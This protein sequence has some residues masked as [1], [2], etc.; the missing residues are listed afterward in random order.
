M[1]APNSHPLP[2]IARRRDPVV[3]RAQLVVG[4]LEAQTSEFR[5]A[6]V[7]CGLASCVPVRRPGP[8]ALTHGRCGVCALTMGTRTSGAGAA[9]RFGSRRWH[10]IRARAGERFAIPDL[11][12]VACLARS[13]LVG[14]PT[15][16]LAALVDLL[17]ERRR[18]AQQ[19]DR[20]PDAHTGNPITRDRCRIP[21]ARPRRHRDRASPG[22]GFLLWNLARNRRPLSAGRPCRLPQSGSPPRVRRGSGRACP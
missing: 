13:G 8:G 16:C 4:A 5:L 14:V 21:G 2:V 6:S 11:Q 20:E 3:E 22:I 19:Q 7:A 12:R 1:R 18:P 15:R 17:R 9:R 10:R